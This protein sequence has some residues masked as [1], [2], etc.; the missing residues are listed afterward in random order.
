MGQVMELWLYCYLVLLS[1]APKS[2]NYLHW[3]HLQDMTHIDQL[4]QERRN[5]SALAMEL[6]LSC[7]NPS[8]WALRHL[9]SLATP[10]F[11]QKLA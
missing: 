2:A 3:L 11:V 10:E 5:P 6:S 8:M 4:V 7:I 9:I 1:T